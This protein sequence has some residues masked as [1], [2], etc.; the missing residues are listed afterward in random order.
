MIDKKYPFD[1]YITP[2]PIR[3]RCTQ[4]SLYVVYGAFMAYIALVIF[5]I[6]WC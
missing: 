2:P 4:A 6:F 3:R 1:T 5:A